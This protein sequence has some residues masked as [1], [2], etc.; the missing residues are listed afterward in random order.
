MLTLSAITRILALRIGTDGTARLRCHCLARSV[1]PAGERGSKFC[2]E[3][4]SAAT[5]GVPRTMPG[6][7]N[8]FL[9]SKR[10]RCWSTEPAGPTNAA[11][12]RGGAMHAGQLHRRR[13][14]DLRQA[15]KRKGAAKWPI[16]KL[17]ASIG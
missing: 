16:F 17:P 13:L 11:W 2:S 7:L 15:A 14:L 12:D 6:S 1:A 9:L 10:A 5:E 4:G 3:R 8:D